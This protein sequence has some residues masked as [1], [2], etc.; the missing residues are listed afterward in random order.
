MSLEG[1][2]DDMFDVLDRHCHPCIL[3]GRWALVWMGTEVIQEQPL[4][5]LIRNTQVSTVSADLVRTGRWIEVPLVPTFREDYLQPPPRIFER[6]DGTFSIKLWSEDAV[7]ILVDPP[8][9]ELVNAN[10][11]FL[12]QALCCEVLNPVLLE[13]DMHPSPEIV[14]RKPR[15]LTTPD[16]RFLP[17]VRCQSTARQ[18]QT[19]VY[20]PTIPRYLDALLAQIRWLQENGYSS[21]KIYGPRE[22]VGFLVRYLFLEMPSQRKKLLPLLKSESVIELVKILDRYKRTSKLRLGIDEIRQVLKGGGGNED[23]VQVVATAEWY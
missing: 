8:A 14:T 16:T 2:L 3:L 1:Y 7:F 20:I 19:K 13:S 6:T 21:L 4:D 9:D 5:L 12:I 11:P 22:D 10:R 18:P 15:L 23:M 17:H